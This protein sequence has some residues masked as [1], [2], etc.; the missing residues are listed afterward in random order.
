MVRSTMIQLWLVDFL[1]HYWVIIFSL[2]PI[3]RPNYNNM[4]KHC[5][6]WCIKNIIV[7]WTK[8]KRSHKISGDNFPCGNYHFVM[9]L[10][11]VSNWFWQV[12]KR[13]FWSENT[14]PYWLSSR[15]LQSENWNWS[16]LLCHFEE[17]FHVRGH[18]RIIPKLTIINLQ[19]LI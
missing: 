9:P 10:I 16:S 12:Y 1:W 19:F 17:P 14:A 11:L 7:G 18:E 5:I 6:F 2:L 13:T 8:L 4:N 3:L 15:S